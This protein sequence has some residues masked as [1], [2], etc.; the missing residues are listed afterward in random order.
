MNQPQWKP[1]LLNQRESSLMQE[2]YFP[3]RWKM[4]ICCLMLNLTSYKQVVPVIDEFFHRWPTA[5]AASEADEMEM[6]ELLKTLGFYN[7]RSKTIIKM[8]K[9]LQT[10]VVCIKQLYGC[11]KYA[12]DSDRI[13]FR[14]LWK[15]TI[16]TDR[17]LQRYI[18][19]LKGYY[20]GASN[21]SV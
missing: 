9:Q 21:E 11:G 12:D 17:V 16:P 3:D 20:K 7:K 2:K 18:D 14:G 15:E 5:K 10:G 8:S 19:F 6:K 1:P 4:L 13:F